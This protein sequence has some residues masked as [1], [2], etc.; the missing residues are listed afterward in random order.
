MTG[1]QPCI[2]LSSWTCNPTIGINIMVL[3]INKDEKKIVRNTHC[4]HDVCLSHWRVVQK[5]V[6]YEF[7]VSVN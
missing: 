3:A 1:R 6:M 2:V 5:I 4:V 7:C